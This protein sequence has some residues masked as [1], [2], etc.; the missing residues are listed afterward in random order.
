MGF[1]KD[2]SDA[3]TGAGK[4]EL[5]GEQL[6][7]Q[8]ELSSQQIETEN[9]RQQLKYSPEAQRTKMLFALVIGLVF[10]GIMFIIFK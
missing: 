1:F 2:L 3:L 4:R 7:T 5:A 10:L 9:L 8:L 6:K